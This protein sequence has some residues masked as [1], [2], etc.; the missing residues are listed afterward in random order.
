MPCH[1]MQYVQ[2]VGPNLFT[3]NENSAYVMPRVTACAVTSYAH[4]AAH[5]CRQASH[6]MYKWHTWNDL[7]MYHLRK[8]NNI[9][10]DYLPHI[11]APKI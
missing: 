8:L 2:N 4:H 3:C 6:P 7:W 9:Y 5:A 10:Q 11:L 1:H